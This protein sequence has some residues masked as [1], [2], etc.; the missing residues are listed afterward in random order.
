MSSV[1]LTEIIIEVVPKPDIGKV[2]VWSFKDT[3]GRTVCFIKASSLLKQCSH[4]FSATTHIRVNYKV[5]GEWSEGSTEFFDSY[6]YNNEYNRKLLHDYNGACHRIILINVKS[7]KKTYFL[8][9]RNRDHFCWKR[10]TDKHRSWFHAHPKNTP[11][12]FVG[13]KYENRKIF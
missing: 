12:W 7:S 1:S 10:R 2:T 3:N 9:F 4:H 11:V 5:A 8:P 6:G 13:H